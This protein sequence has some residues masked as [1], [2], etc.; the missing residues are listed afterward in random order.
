MRYIKQIGFV[1]FAAAALATACDNNNE[2][3]VQFGPDK[4]TLT[5]G[6]EG[7]TQSV[8]IS[9]NES[10]LAS[11]DQAWI[12][13]SPANGDS[14][15]EC[16]IRIDSTY[17][18]IMRD[19]EVRFTS[20]G[21]TRTVKINQMGFSKQIIVEGAEQGVYNVDLP[22]YAA[23]GKTFFDV[24]VTT[25]VDFK[26]EIN[27]KTVAP[28]GEQQPGGPTAT[29]L[30][31]KDF[32]LD[33]VQSKPR[34]VKIRF[35]WSYN[36][37]WWKQNAQIRFVPTEQTTLVQ[38]DEV[39]VVQTEAPRITDDRAGD[40]IAVLSI[41]RQLNV[42]SGGFDASKNM[43]DWGENIELYRKADGNDKDGKPL[44]GRVKYVRFFFFDTKEGIPYETRYLTRAEEIIFYGNTNNRTRNIELGTSL[45]EL[46][47]YGYLKKLTL[48]AYGFNEL[49]DGFEQLG[50]TLEKLNLG[51]EN[52]TE[53]P[54]I[55]TPE[56]FPHLKVLSIGANR[57]TEVYDLSNSVV[58]KPGLGGRLPEYLFRWEKL[59][60]LTLSYNYFEGSIPAM[61]NHPILWTAEDGYP[62]LVGKPKILPNAK[63]LKV[64]LNRLTGELPD[65]LLNH[66]YVEEWMPD[67]FIFTQE[68]KDSKGKNAGFSNIPDR[69][70]PPQKEE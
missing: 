23:Y 44:E 52:F 29:W 47:K 65:W 2:D 48:E 14:S 3:S 54:G 63:I 61:K 32:K 22:D 46:A 69:V 27:E 19:G 53:I 45:L 8:K 68:G 5:V 31:N 66:P 60:E 39:A 28:E 35:N 64:N 20:A 62:T 43:L 33:L 6:P 50:T 16:K 12:L 51:S 4:E 13:I 41:A 56:N 42:G 57:T 18:D 49:P 25:N 70:T 1:L 17:Q 10:W 59:E 40:S 34:T 26:V 15:L 21:Q 55:L 37:K 11:T 36:T 24:N 38:Q 9:A 30:T 7:G 67:T 58:D